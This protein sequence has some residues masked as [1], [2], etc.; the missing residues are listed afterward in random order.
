VYDQNEPPPKPTGPDYDR[1]ATWSDIPWVTVLGFVIFVVGAL[2]AWVSSAGPEDE[3]Q[4][5]SA[6]SLKVGDCFNVSRGLSRF[7]VIPLPCSEMHQ[8]QVYRVVTASLGPADPD[9]C[10]EKIEEVGLNS[11]QVPDTAK[12]GAIEPTEAGLNAGVQRV[13][14][15]IEF[16]GGHGSSVVPQD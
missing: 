6:G 3:N 5:A 10:F 11:G 9:E 4:S 2:T 13:V 1:R 8:R 16:P 12:L 15:F 14:C 7:E